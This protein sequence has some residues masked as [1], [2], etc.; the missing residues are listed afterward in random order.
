MI[1]GLSERIAISIIQGYRYFLSPYFG[2]HCRFHPTCSAY[3]I[4]AIQIHGVVRGV[5]LAARRLGRC[6]PLHQGGFD[7]VPLPSTNSAEAEQNSATTS[8]GAL[9]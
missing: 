8:S 3:A 7:P 2:Q 1:D 5:M 6:H 9:Q 4:E